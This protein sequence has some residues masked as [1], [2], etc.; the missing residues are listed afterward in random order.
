MSDGPARPPVGQH[1]T[2]TETSAYTYTDI[3][4]KYTHIKL[5]Y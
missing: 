3:K 2:W 4:H 1:Y 5:R